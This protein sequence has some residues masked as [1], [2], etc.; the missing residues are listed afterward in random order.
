MEFVVRN[1]NGALWRISAMFSGFVENELEKQSPSWGKPPIIS[2][3]SRNGNV[4]KLR[5]PTCVTYTHPLEHVLFGRYRDANPFFHVFEAMWMLAGRNDL[6]PLLEFVKD[7]GQF[8]DDGIY[9]N[10]AYGYRWR[11]AGSED[12]DLDQLVL[13]ANH[14]KQN[15]DSRRAVLQMWNVEDDLMKIGGIQEYDEETGYPLPNGSK[16]V[17]CNLSVLF[18]LEE[19]AIPSDN[20]YVLNMTVYNRSNDLV[21]GCLGANYVHFS[22]LMEYMATRIGV[23]VGEYHQVSNDLHFYTGKKFDLTK[24]AESYD[25][26]WYSDNRERRHIPLVQDADRFDNEVESFVTWKHGIAYQE[27]F[28]ATV[29]SPMMLVHTLHKEG[30]DIQAWEATQYISA[31]DWQEACRQWLTTRMEKKGIPCPSKSN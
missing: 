3:T 5:R 11:F 22:F 18:S 19:S 24:L 28:L 23:G 2:K 25:T 6:Q 30:K 16:D 13:I 26:D 29:A 10:G 21:L 8:S 20:G 17:C 14:L 4:L 27:P 15:P 12:H 9:L 7:F 1:V 31:T